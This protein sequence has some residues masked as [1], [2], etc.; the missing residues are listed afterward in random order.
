MTPP[1]LCIEAKT[2]AIWSQMHFLI[3]LMYLVYEY[4]CLKEK[5]NLANVNLMSE[6]T[7]RIICLFPV[8]RD[9][10]RATGC[11]WAGERHYSTD[12]PGHRRQLLHRHLG[13]GPGNLGGWRGKKIHSAWSAA[14]PGTA[15][16]DNQKES[17]TLPPR[18]SYHQNHLQGA[19]RSLQ[20]LG[21]FTGHP[22]SARPDRQLAPPGEVQT[23]PNVMSQW[24]LEVKDSL[25]LQMY[26]PSLLQAEVWQ[27][28]SSILST[29]FSFPFCPHTLAKASRAL[30]DRL[31]H[32][33]P[34]FLRGLLFRDAT[35]IC[36]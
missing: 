15:G 11:H 18:M 1:H 2:S 14:L 19:A 36:I 27:L 22:R 26:F 32:S 5:K 28:S 13:T 10:Q 9:P 21:N 24:I 6:T 23:P 7:K 8:G 29:H 33:F 25:T 3:L 12:T 4:S 34:P 16:K 17:P 20:A 30:C 31:L 35:Y